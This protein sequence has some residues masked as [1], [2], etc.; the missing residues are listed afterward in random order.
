MKSQPPLGSAELPGPRS[1]EICAREQRVASPGAQ[2]IATL[3][4]L[5][6]ERGEGALLWD[7]DGNAYID[8]AAGIGVASIG[9]GHPRYARALAEQVARFSVGSFSTERRAR[10]LELLVESAP[11][12]LDR[13]QLFSSGAEAVE[14]AL[15][16]AKSATSRHE[17]MGFWG[18]FHGKTGGVLG[19]LGSE[20]KHGLGPLAPGTYLSP[21]PDPYRPPAGLRG[22]DLATAC[23]E[24]LRQ[25]IR[26]ETTN[27]IAAI[28]V[29]PVQGTAGN[30]FPPLGFLS[31]LRDLATE[32]GA[33]L[34]V[35]EMIT[36]F[37]RTGRMFACG[38]DGVV[39]DVLLVGKGMGGGY[40][41]SGLIARDAF[42][43]ARPYA[44]PSGNS[45]SYGGNPLAAAAALATLEILREEEL[46]ERSRRVGAVLL[47]RLRAVAHRVPW[48]GHVEGEG[49]LLRLEL[50]RDRSTREPLPGAI[51]VEIFQECLRRGLLTMAYSPSV[52]INPPLVLDEELAERGAAILAEVLE[53]VAERH[54]GI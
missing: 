18:G 11:G 29:E 51:C 47:E 31:G 27:R 28:V 1:R 39:P 34:I 41:V 48:I 14:A 24:F 9:H 44:L 10:L 17:V 33:L 46:V 35:D 45:S 23:L 12:N 32:I 50:V 7:V 25:K 54:S 42:A 15:R 26:S 52:R 21:Y 43:Q 36:G 40:P 22:D 30:V 53:L 37:G 5:A 38:R 3:A 8:F 2:K 13:A 19:I 4:G 49:L 6:L 16:L 20:F